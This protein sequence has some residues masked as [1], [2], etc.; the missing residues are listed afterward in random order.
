[1][2]PEVF[3]GS[4]ATVTSGSLADGFLSLR[5]GDTIE[6]T[7]FDA[8]AAATRNATA[9]GDLQP[10]V[11][12]AV[13]VASGFGKMII[14]WNT[15][16]SANSLVRYGA[17]A[18]LPS[19][20]TN[21]TF[22][23]THE[24]LLEGLTTGRT[25]FFLVV[26]SDLAGNTATNDNN[27][28]LYSFVAVGAPTVLLVDNFETDDFGFGPDIPLTTYTDALDEAGVAYEV[29]DLVGSGVSPT[30]NDLRP[31]RAVIWRLSDNVFI[32]NTLSPQEQT[33]VQQY[34]AGGGSFFMA[35]MEQLTRLGSVFRRDVLQVSSFG[36]DDGV[37]FVTGASGNPVT[38]G[39]S[40]PLDYSNYQ[41]ESY[42]VFQVPDDVS[43]T[44]TPT[45]N[46]APIFFSSGGGG[47]RWPCL[48]E[49]RPQ[50]SRARRLPV[51]PA[52][53]RPRE[54]VRAQ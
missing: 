24:V 23:Q 33:V 47:Y 32:G 13:S 43:D 25:Y 31:Y 20:A 35:G 26:S 51:V 1:M 36:E 29:W 39:M 14:R 21:R 19:T 22:A 28:L 17:D 3:T 48:T 27:G 44:M 34:V 42:E 18:S 40:I 38:A 10:P 8:S 6:A 41:I 16:E 53:C 15:D 37:P 9:R 54:C 45:T 7:Y 2:V 12:S 11:I 49:N 52:G 5:H 46:A 50:P 4:V 30:L